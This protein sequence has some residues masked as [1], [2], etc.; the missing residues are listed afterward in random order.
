MHDGGRRWSEPD[1][2][3]WSVMIPVVSC[4][5]AWH[6]LILFHITLP[7]SL[8]TKLWSTPVLNCWEFNPETHRLEGLYLYHYKGMNTKWR[9]G[10][11]K[12]LLPVQTVWMC[13]C[14][15]C[16]QEN[17]CL[18]ARCPLSPVQSG[19]AMSSIC[20]F[21]SQVR[22]WGGYRTSYCNPAGEQ[23]IEI[24]ILRAAVSWFSGQEV[25]LKNKAA[26]CC[27]E[28]ARWGW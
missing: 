19:S 20:C 4:R 9:D 10:W 26:Q 16:P 5:L 24:G 8:A 2:L 1:P 25:L 13:R 21:L 28:H 7:A 14:G 17:P 15:T 6:Y 23:R 11:Q 12:R 3:Y 22:I 18:I 27:K